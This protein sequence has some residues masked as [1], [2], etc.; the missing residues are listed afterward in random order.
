MF[1]FLIVFISYK[2]QNTQ[3]FMIA[4]LMMT[5]MKMKKG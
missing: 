3:V 1:Y 2:L 5:S 4:V